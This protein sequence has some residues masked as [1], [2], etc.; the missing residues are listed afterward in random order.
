M[1]WQELSPVNLR[2][3]FISEWQRGIRSI[4]ELCAEYAVSRRTGYKWIAR[5]Q[6]QGPR[7]L[8][9]Q[10]RRPHESPDA[11][12]PRIVAQ[13]VALRHAHPSWGPRKLLK[14]ARQ[15][16]PQRCWPCRAT[17][18]RLLKARGLVRQRPTRSRPV[19]A[20]PLGL[21]TRANEVWTTD[22]KGH[23]RTGDRVYCYPLT[24]RDGFSR[25]VLRC[26]ALTTTRYEPTRRCFEQAFAAYGLPERI[27]SDNG[28]PFA[29]T[30]LAGL[31]RLSV[32]WLR[33]GIRLERIAP[34]H[35]EQNGSHEQFHRVLKAETTRPPAAH[36]RAQ[37]QRF[38]A[39]VREYNQ[40]RP[41]EALGDEVPA[42]YFT[43]SP[44]VLPVRLP[45]LEYPGHFEVRRVSLMGQCGWRNHVLFLSGALAGELVGFEEI[46]DGL[47][48]IYY[49]DV[50][51]GRFDERHRRLYPLASLTGGRS[52]SFAGSAPVLHT[53]R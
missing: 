8:H 6:A 9:D 2:M 38:T 19:A 24:L 52:A 13:L 22:F 50:A 18:W 36:A 7:G 33:L 39:F 49:A 15:R 43:P 25:Y 10:S 27:R 12:D 28:G 29:S 53:K 34:G 3:H 42:R 45:P 14:K 30:G 46:D 21:I 1:P 48:T 17:V 32:W 47:W 5:F 26:D 23:F 51:L 41:H 44:R 40:E 4:T 35:P 31:S 11:T 16:D 20:H 37:Q